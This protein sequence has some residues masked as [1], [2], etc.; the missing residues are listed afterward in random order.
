MAL[1]TFDR[2]G[3]TGVAASVP[4]QKIVNAECTGFFTIEEFQSA[5]QK[6]GI[7]E[8][9]AAYKKTCA[10]DLCC[11]AAEALLEETSIDRNE[12]DVL[13]FVYQTPDCRMPVTG[14]SCKIVWD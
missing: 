10:S 14:L 12:I 4:K 5:I 13:I 3:I 2:I 9:R 1:L 6:S 8:R 11:A 7:S